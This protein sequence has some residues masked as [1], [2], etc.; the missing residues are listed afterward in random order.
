M[1]QLEKLRRNDVRTGIQLK[2]ELAEEP[3]EEKPG[4]KIHKSCGLESHIVH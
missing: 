3:W 2:Q 1:G 4:M